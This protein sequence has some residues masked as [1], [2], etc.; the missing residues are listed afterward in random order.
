MIPRSSTRSRQDALAFVVLVVVASI[1]GGCGMTRT[2]MIENQS[3]EPVVA[4]FSDRYQAG[5]TRWLRASIAPGSTFEYALRDGPTS[6]GTV[7][8]IRPVNKSLVEP[9]TLVVPSSETTRVKVV[10]Q[11]EQF[12]LQRVR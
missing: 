1:L 12:Q 4:D 10:R 5:P 9:L 6:P 3:D 7:L 8:E 11:P 2:V